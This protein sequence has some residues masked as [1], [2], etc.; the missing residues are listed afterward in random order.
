MHPARIASVVLVVAISLVAPLASAQPLSEH[1]AIVRA[2]RTSPRLRAALADRDAASAQVRAADG[3][4][5]PVLVLGASGYHTETFAGASNGVARNMQDGGSV[6]GA[7]RFSTDLGTTIE[8]GIRSAIGWRSVNRDPSTTTLFTIGP[9]YSGEV[10]LGLRQPLLRGAGDDATLAP[11]RQAEAARLAAEQQ[12]AQSASQL[13]L[14]VLVAHRELWYAEEAHRVTEESLAATRR[15][16]EE[17]RL[18]FEELGTIP[19]TEM[20]RYASERA[21]VEQSVARAQ[22]EV[23]SRAIELG[24]LLGLSPAESLALRAGIADVDPAPPAT[25]ELLAEA[26]SQRSPELLALEA[27]LQAA[28]ERERAARDADQPRLDLTSDLAVGALFNDTTIG[29]FQLPGDRPAFS[30]MV[31][32]E[33]ELPLGQSQQ[34]AERQIAASQHDSARA[35]YE[36]RA[37][38]IV[39]ETAQ[40]RTEIIAAAR[41]VELAE[42]AAALA[43]ELAEAERQKVAL[44]TATALEVVQAQQAEREA[45]LAGLRARADYAAAEARLAHVTGVL[46]DRFAPDA[47]MGG[48]S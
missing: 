42:D 14:D 15:Q 24:R 46:I 9:N 31:G 16:H 34:S 8:L 48:A 25:L 29:P 18:R 32:V 23:E 12:V 19:R 44:G 33:F 4:R 21:S 11:R 39:A 26:A 1:D 47:R 27:D 36:E 35:R 45:V 2:L 5:L 7:V 28:A 17:S 10:T 41:R 37:Q 38:A 22:A 13:V 20:L 3:A 30:A 6:D 40:R 43:R